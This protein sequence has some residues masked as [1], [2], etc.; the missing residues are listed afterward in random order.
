MRC[1]H[2][3]KAPRILIARLVYGKAGA[4]TDWK[5][6]VLTMVYREGQNK[7]FGKTGVGL[8]GTMFYVV[9]DD[10]E[11]E[12][13]YFDA[14]MAADGSEDGIASFAI[15][16]L[17]VEEF[18]KL[19]PQV[20]HLK[21][22]RTDGAG[23]YSGLEFLIGLALMDEN[24]GLPVLEHHIGEAGNNKKSQDG[25]FGMLGQAFRRLVASGD[26]DM[27]SELAI[28][29]AIKK[30][31]L[32]NTTALFCT[33][34]SSHVIKTNRSRFIEIHADFSQ[35]PHSKYLR[36]RSS[37]LVTFSYVESLRS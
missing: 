25:H 20:K 2:E 35:P 29:Q 18:K 5:A 32:A 15:F 12:I 34:E 4:I 26:H 10:G 23:C 9:T 30:I 17:S 6:K 7:F 14:V 3:S 36:D 1:I 21:W 33:P 24:D 13:S 8:M 28:A 22:V 31:G 11:I 37:Y 27:D 19:Y 16:K